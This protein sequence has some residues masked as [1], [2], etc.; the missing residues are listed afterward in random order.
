M[1]RSTA[2]LMV[3]LSSLSPGL[4]VAGNTDR[5]GTAG[6]SELFIPVG[7]RG[8]AM[9]A[10]SNE[11]LNGVEALY[12]NPAGLS[13]MS[14]GVEG[15]FSHMSYI[16]DVNVDYGAVGI[17]AG[18]FGSLGF[19][20]KSIAF[21]DIP[22][23]TEEFP[24]GTGQTYSPTFLNIGATYSNRL[25]DRISVGATATVISEKIMS[26]SATGIAFSVGVEYSN[27][28][29]PGLG[30]SV[31][32]KN[33]G[34]NMR[35]DGSDLLRQTSG[36]NN[37]RG[38]QLTA[39][40]AATFELPSAIEI[41][42]GYQRKLD[43]LNTATVGGIFRNNNSTV[44]EYGVGGEYSYNDLLFL[45]GGYTFAPQA[46]TDPT[47]TSS[48]IFDYTLG[49]GIHSIVGGVDLSFDYAYRHVKYFDGNQAVTLRFGF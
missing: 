28:G 8:I 45:R 29:V 42:I 26:T 13:R 24:D 39:V 48:Y 43:D 15:L 6:A 12:Y 34:P 40:Q 4:A 14:H 46:T 38:P 21:G 47:G 30:L 2:A 18:D 31:A 49:A 10:A 11:F 3:L 23:T 1:N 37:L 44:D 17:S 20:L 16:A 33:I 7:A 27:L 41:G 5:T 36:T 35:F 32:V 22:V 19:S 25:T 9:G